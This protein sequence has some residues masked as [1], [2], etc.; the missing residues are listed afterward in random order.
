MQAPC[1]IIKAGGDFYGEDVPNICS[2]R[3]RNESAGGNHLESDGHFHV[4][5]GRHV[6]ESSHL[7]RGIPFAMKLP[8]EQPVAMASLTKEQFERELQKGIEDVE[9]GRGYS[10]D[11]IEREMNLLYGV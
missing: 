5:C 6:F 9:H 4:P 10:A 8:T 11:L 3:T 2:R 1:F 7:Q